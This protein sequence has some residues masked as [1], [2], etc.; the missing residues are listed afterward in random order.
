MVTDVL[1]ISGITSI[2][3]AIP[4]MISAFA[5]N[6]PPRLALALFLLGGGL[7]ASAMT[8]QPGGYAPQEIPGAF[9]RVLGSILN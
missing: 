4:S 9:V 3:L 8:M 1:L 6:R 2:L 5:E 7:A